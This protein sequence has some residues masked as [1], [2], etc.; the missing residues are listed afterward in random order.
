[1]EEKLTP[2]IVTHFR[3]NHQRIRT[4]VREEGIEPID[5]TEKMEA[6]HRSGKDPYR[7]DVHPNALGNQVMVDELF[8][9][10]REALTQ[11]TTKPSTRPASARIT[12]RS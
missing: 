11:A 8:P 4:E 5:W 1:M 6:L 7:D 2:E 9:V 3:G 12:P 10:L